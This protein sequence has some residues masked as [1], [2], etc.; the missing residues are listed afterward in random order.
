MS[1]LNRIGVTRPGTWAIAHVV[2]P[3]Q[4]R[5]LVATRGRVS[6]TGNR[7]VLF[8]HDD[9]SSFGAAPDDSAVLL[10]RR[11]R[12]GRLQ[13]PSAFRTPEPMAPQR[14]SEPERIRADRARDRAT[15]R[16]RSTRARG[17]EVLAALGQDVARLRALLRG[18]ARACHL[19][20]AATV[21][22]R[23][24]ELPQLAQSDT[25]RFTLEAVATSS[26]AALRCL[27]RRPWPGRSSRCRP[28]GWSP[29]CALGRSVRARRV[30][31]RVQVVRLR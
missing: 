5:L 1:L 29:G 23:P 8:A 21:T 3:L 30:R 4:R 12:S 19:R 26:L 27:A 6:L 9:G 14:A 31:R 24:I 15:G 28:R 11:R 25:P 20:V 7:P 13:R 10:A 16:E 17:R 2:S 22:F 18:H